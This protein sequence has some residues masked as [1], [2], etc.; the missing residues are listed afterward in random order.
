ML[1]N[2]LSSRKMRKMSK[3]PKRNPKYSTRYIGCIN[4]FRN[5]AQQNYEKKPASTLML[6]AFMV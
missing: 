2:R 1:K 6:N 3:E 4:M 5:F